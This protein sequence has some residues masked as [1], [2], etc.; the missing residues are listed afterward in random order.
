MSG[1]FNVCALNDG[2]ALEK[3]CSHC[4]DNSFKLKCSACEMVNY[5]S[6]KCQVTAIFISHVSYICSLLKERR[7]QVS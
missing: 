1:K 2:K 7:Y 3:N 6:E 4:L 5:C